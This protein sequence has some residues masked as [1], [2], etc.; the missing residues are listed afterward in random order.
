MWEY[1][2]FK[3]ESKVFECIFLF[4]GGMISGENILVG[5]PLHDLRKIILAS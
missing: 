5:D 1:V 4:F 3:W 2:Y